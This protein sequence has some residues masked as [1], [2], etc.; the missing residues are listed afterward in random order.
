MLAI[1]P[2]KPQSDGALSTRSNAAGQCHHAIAV[3][4]V[5]VLPSAHLL[6]L[7][8]RDWVL[9]KALLQLG[10]ELRGARQ[11]RV[12]QAQTAFERSRPR[13][14]RQPAG[15]GCCAGAAR[16]NGCPAQSRPPTSGKAATSLWYCENSLL[17]SRC[18]RDQTECRSSL[19]VRSSPVSVGDPSCLPSM[20]YIL[21]YETPYWALGLA[22]TDLGSR[23]PY[24]AC[25]Q[26]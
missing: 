12:R 5:A 20:V 15:R 7:H 19:L 1:T 21:L 17:A 14:G 22:R 16:D 13:Q 4:L 26:R 6:Q 23:T 9:Q 8:L 10:T 25:R 3:S 24:H 18:C 11:A 2:T